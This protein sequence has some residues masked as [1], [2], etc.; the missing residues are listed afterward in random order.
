MRGS[1]VKDKTN[2][3]QNEKHS[4][5]TNIL[6]K[7]TLDIT[8]LIEEKI[9]ELV[10]ISTKD[11]HIN[12]KTKRYNIASMSFLSRSYIISEKLPQL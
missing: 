9:Y 5:Q 3:T 11:K 2:P 6:L 1:K 7:L 8:F 4:G 10:Q 12:R